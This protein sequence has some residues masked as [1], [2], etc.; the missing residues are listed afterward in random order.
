LTAAALW[1]NPLVPVSDCRDPGDDKYLELALAARA[2]ILISS[3][4]DLLALDP[5]R[6]VHIVRPAEFLR[7][8][9]V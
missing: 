9:S 1:F 5:W 3:D 2:A 7:L 6:G 4:E 8:P